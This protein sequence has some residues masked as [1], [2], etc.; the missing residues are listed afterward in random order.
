MR[1]LGFV[2]LLAAMLAALLVVVVPSVGRTSGSAAEAAVHRY[3]PHRGV[4]VN[5]PLGDRA[6]RRAIISQILRSIGRAHKGSKIRIST[7]NLRS[8]DIVDALIAA[9]RRGVSVRVVIDRGNAN[10]DNPNDGFDR[11]QARL[12]ASMAKNHRPQD[13]TSFATVC[14]G[15]CRARGGIAHTK[16]FL[17]SHTGTARRVVMYSSANATDLAAGYQWKDMFT[18]IGRRH[19]FAKFVSIFDQMTRDRAVKSPYQ[20][21]LDGRL[22][23]IFFPYAGA[24]A[25]GDPVMRELGRVRCAGATGGTGVGGKTSIRIAMTAW[26]GERGLRIAGRLKQ[27]YNRGCDMRIIYG[28]IGNRVKSL[29]RSR[30][31]RG[32]IE[33]EQIAQDWDADGVYDRYLHMKVMTVSG[34]Y[35]GDSS[36]EVAWN[37][38]SNWTPLSL[39]SDEAGMR[40][41][42]ARV[43][44]QYADWIDHLYFNPPPSPNL[45]IDGDGIEGRRGIDPYAKMQ[46]D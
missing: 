42:S 19:L 4:L 46:I 5:D 28:V 12:D 40:I 20:T 10:P 31:G 24:R 39:R 32:P 23:A 9:D 44:R 13:M 7:W 37:G 11:L 18:V 21:L 3:T 43:R 26:T 2:G 25:K 1:R 16:M 27:M 34:V 41:E 22:E 33:V 35:G 17:F 15:A 8:N 36:A 30:S 6:A 45:D 38:S 14:A 29:L